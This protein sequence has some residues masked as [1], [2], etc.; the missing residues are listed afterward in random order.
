VQ[1]SGEA[2]VNGIATV[3]ANAIAVFSAIGSVNG[4]ATVVCLGRILGDEWTDET[5]GSESWTP[6]TPSAD[7]WVDA[8]ADS[9]SWNNVPAN[10][11]NWTDKSIGNQT[12]Q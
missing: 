9:T 4:E 1:Y 8:S 6:E 5:A 12:W 11:P 10:N 2:S 7:V 3:N